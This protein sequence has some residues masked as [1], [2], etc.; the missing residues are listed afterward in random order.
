[1]VT[2][3]YGRP[4]SRSPVEKCFLLAAAG[5]LPGLRCQYQIGN[6]Y[7]DFAIPE[8]KIAIEID[9]HKWHATQEQR[10]RDNARAR[11]IMQQGWVVIR[12]T[13]REVFQAPEFCVQEVRKIVVA[14]Q[15]GNCS[16]DE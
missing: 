9:G 3:R 6:Y 16:H 8:K 5:Q 2:P 12:F 10:E 7:I 11:Y 4:D 15:R 14:H 1:M 13:G